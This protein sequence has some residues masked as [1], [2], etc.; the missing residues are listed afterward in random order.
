MDPV[1]DFLS[2][3][4]TIDFEAQTA[5]LPFVSRQPQV[6]EVPPRT[7]GPYHIGLFDAANNQLAD[8]PFTPILNTEGAAQQT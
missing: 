2:V 6:S 4:G 7:E 1:G 5:S 3:Y 8:Y